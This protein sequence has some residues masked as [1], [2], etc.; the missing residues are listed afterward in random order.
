MITFSPA[1]VFVVSRLHEELEL[2]ILCRDAVFEYF[3]NSIFWTVRHF[4]Q[5]S[6]FRG[7]RGSV[8]RAR[9]LCDSFPVY[10]LCHAIVVDGEGAVAPL[11]YPVRALGGRFQLSFLFATVGVVGVNKDVVCL[12][13]FHIRAAH[14]VFEV[15]LVARLR[16]FKRLSRR[17]QL[18][19]HAGPGCLV[20][21]DIAACG[22][23]RK[24][25]VADS[26]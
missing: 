20:P 4:V 18:G 19:I 12:T 25:V 10:D 23:E 8:V 2:V 13:D 1:W 5:L 24:Q 15:L 16:F 26:V 22:A 6:W 14:P 3:L 11:L 9:G 21:G 17:E 7:E